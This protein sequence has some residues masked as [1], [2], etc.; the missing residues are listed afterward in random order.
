MALNGY[1]TLLF[2]IHIIKH[3]AL[4]NLNCLSVFQESV[5]QCTLA[6]INVGYNAEISDFVHIFKF[7]RKDNEKNG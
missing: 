3:L 5:S 2:Q 1:T 6:M 4:S 7:L